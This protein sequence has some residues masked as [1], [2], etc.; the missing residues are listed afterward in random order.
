MVLKSFSTSFFS[1]SKQRAYS[2]QQVQFFYAV[3]VLGMLFPSL[4]FASGYSQVPPMPP[5]PWGSLIE[6]TTNY[7]IDGESSEEVQAECLEKSAVKELDEKWAEHLPW[8]NT[9]IL[10]SFFRDGDVEYS[11]ETREV[12]LYSGRA[13]EV[14]NASEY[15]KVREYLKN[16]E[17]LC[18]D[19]AQEINE[20]AAQPM[21]LCL[22]FMYGEYPVNGYSG[23]LPIDTS[24]S[25]GTSPLLLPYG[26]SIGPAVFKSACPARDGQLKNGLFGVQIPVDIVADENGQYTGD[27]GA[28]NRYR[29]EAMPPRSQ[30][31]PSNCRYIT[32]T[33][34][35]DD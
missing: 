1:V 16:D 31:R 21:F 5:Q 15:K 33:D 9:G 28:I 12:S 34:S 6:F 35:D 18:A 3:V 32:A 26:C 17:D 29:R 24:D 27:L 30:I 25:S 22:V 19:R 2:K 14:F 8:E 20:D 23:P 4:T 10:Y 11:I 13:D 7:N